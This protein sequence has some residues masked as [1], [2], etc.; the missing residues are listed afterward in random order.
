M[1]TTADF[2]IYTQWAGILTLACGLIAIL[3]FIFKWGLRF[4]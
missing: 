1:P 2:L 3:G 4:R